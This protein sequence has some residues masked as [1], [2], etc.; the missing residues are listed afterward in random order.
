MLWQL[1]FTLSRQK[2]H[3]MLAISGWADDYY[4]YIQCIYIFHNL[5]PSAFY[6]SCEQVACFFILSPAIPSYI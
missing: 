4:L 1:H 3:K 5:L 6:G 2:K